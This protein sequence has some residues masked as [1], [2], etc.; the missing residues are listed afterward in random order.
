MFSPNLLNILLNSNL[1]VF[2]ETRFLEVLLALFLLLGLKV[3]G[4]GGVAPLAVAMVALDVLIVLGLL[5]HHNLVNTPLT[6]GGNGSNV[7]CNL[8]TLPLPGGPG[9]KSIV[10][11]CSMMMLLVVVVVVVV[12][13]SSSGSTV[14][15]IEGEGVQEGLGLTV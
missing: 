5:N 12:V 8:I 3:S 13:S 14:A 1:L 15:G 10:G 9:W 4:V 2:N 6:S 7:Q 11:M